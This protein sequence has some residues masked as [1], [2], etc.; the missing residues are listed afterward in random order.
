MCWKPNKGVLLIY[1]IKVYGLCQDL[2][3]EVL[4]LSY[5]S[6]NSKYVGGGCLVEPV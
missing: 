3:L 6:L 2:G 5:S 1:V 4:S